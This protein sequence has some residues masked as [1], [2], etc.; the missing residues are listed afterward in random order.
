MQAEVFGG[1]GLLAPGAFGKGNRDARLAEKSVVVFDPHHSL[2]MSII[3]K[4]KFV[5]VENRDWKVN[6]QRDHLCYREKHSRACT[7]V[8]KAPASGQWIQDVS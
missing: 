4:L 2:N 8:A 6:F 5:Q 3:F 7:D 1:N